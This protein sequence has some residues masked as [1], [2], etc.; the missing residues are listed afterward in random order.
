MKRRMGI[1]NNRMKRPTL[2][3]HEPEPATHRAWAGVDSGNGVVFVEQG[4][5]CSGYVVQRR[6]RLITEAC[7]KAL[8]W[9]RRSDGNP[10]PLRVIVLCSRAEM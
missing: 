3:S 4:E 6:E 2:M 7:M 8:V 1:V 9:K 10:M 5:G